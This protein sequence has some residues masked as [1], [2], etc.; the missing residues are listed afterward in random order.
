MGAKFK[1][2]KRIDEMVSSEVME[3]LDNASVE[4]LGRS[5]KGIKTKPLMDAG[6]NTVASIINSDITR[7]RRV[8]GL[9]EEAARKVKKIAN[10]YMIDAKKQVKI[11]LSADNKSEAASN[12]IVAVTEYI[13]GKEVSDDEA[14]S[15]FSAD[16]ISYYTSIEKIAPGV[17]GNDDTKYG[18]PEELAKDVNEQSV[19]LE[20]LNC[21]LRRY[22]EWGV[23]YALRQERVLL[24]DEM[25]LG[26]TV[27]A[28]AVMASLKNTGATHFLVVCPASLITN[29]CREIAK[30]CSIPVVRIH[31]S[32]REAAIEKWKDEGGAGVTTYETTGYFTFDEEYKFNLLIVDEAHYIKNKEAQRTRNTLNISKHA[33]RM[34]FMTGTAMEN[35]VDEMITLMSYLKPD[36][37]SSVKK[38][39]F[40]SAAKQ[41]RDKIAPVYYRRKREDVLKEL[42][43]KIETREWCTL[44]P[45]EEKIYEDFT[46]K[47]KFMDM[48]RVSWNIDDLTLSAKANRLREIAEEAEED[49]RKILVFS[50]FLD[51]IEKVSSLFGDKCMPYINGALTPEK[52]QSIIDDFEKAPAGTILPAQI[53]SGGTGLNIQSAS[54]VVICEPQLKPSIENQAISRA[55]RMGQSRNVLVYRLLADDTVDERLLERLEEKQKEFDAFADLSA[56]AAESYELDKKL[57]G[58]IIQEEIDRINAKNGYKAEDTDIVIEKTSDSK[59]DT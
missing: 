48:R 4:E 17:L 56:A 30:F 31:G 53:Q 5:E 16:P 19:S 23:K 40:M 6:L 13:S 59:D 12:L 7:L 21:T 25:G 44:G 54:V 49:G 46:R 51:T 37:S 57:I 26:K 47:K 28:I 43:E 9:G 39:S 8:D 38:L 29:W 14:W 41:F 42:P 3:I 20:G 52:R 45:E 11:R 10:D 15:L 36:I 32:D 24:G 55:Y 34:L 27:Q 22:Q 35:N 2:K 18:L 58:D 33:D 1:V 50:F